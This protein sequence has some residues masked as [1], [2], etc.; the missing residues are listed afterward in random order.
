M[1]EHL[2]GDE[3]F[4]GFPCEGDSLIL[5]VFYHKS[6]AHKICFHH[7]LLHLRQTLL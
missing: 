5:L 4:G 2:G 1:S 7:I 3:G 6:P